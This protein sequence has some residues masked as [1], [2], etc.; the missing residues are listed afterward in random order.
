MTRKN[1]SA[2][3]QLAKSN[4]KEKNFKFGKKEKKS[5]AAYTGREVLCLVRKQ[6]VSGA[7]RVSCVRVVR[8][9]F[10]MQ[11]PSDLVVG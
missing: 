7:G 2:I 6:N 9:G 11:V 5:Q 3:Q 1:W 4:K 10:I 8:K